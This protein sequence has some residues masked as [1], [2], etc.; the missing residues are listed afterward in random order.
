MKRTIE[1]YTSDKKLISHG[2]EEMGA[3]ERLKSN[4][5]EIKK[6]SL[7]DE[8]LR[9]KR[10]LKEKEAANLKIQ[11]EMLLLRGENDDLR[12]N[13]NFLLQSKFLE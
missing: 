8:I 2:F 12:T 11:S 4:Y 10:M 5:S 1:S 9:L 6:T 3:P 13:L 7:E